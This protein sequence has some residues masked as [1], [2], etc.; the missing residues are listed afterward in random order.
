MVEEYT[1][2]DEMPEENGNKK[3]WIILGI[4]LAVLC[5][6]CAVVGGAGYWLYYNGDA[7]LGDALQD[8]SL[9][10]FNSFA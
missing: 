2:I 10:I 1:P 3:L 9:Q 8:Y 5:C 4:V 6:C 7:W